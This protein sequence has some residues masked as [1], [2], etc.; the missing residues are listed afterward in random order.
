MSKPHH[1]KGYTL[2]TI[3]IKETNLRER[4]K[5]KGLTQTA[6]ARELGVTRSAVKHWEIGEGI[7]EGNLEKLCQLLK[8][9]PEDISIVREIEWGTKKR[10]KRKGKPLGDI[11]CWTCPDKGT[12]RC[13]EQYCEVMLCWM[14]FC[15]AIL[16]N[17][18]K[19]KLAEFLGLVGGHTPSQNEI[20]YGKI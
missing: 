16:P 2:L 1:H 15:A 9:Y 13:H 7:S 6:L 18:Y 20:R 19:L 14:I 17:D 5:E 8:C 11:K 10:E 4:R 12:A 3:K